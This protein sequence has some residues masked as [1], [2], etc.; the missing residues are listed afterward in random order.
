MPEP[1][2]DLKSAFAGIVA[3]ARAQV[4]ERAGGIARPRR[5]RRPPAQ[6]APVPPRSIRQRPGRGDS[7]TIPQIHRARVIARHAAKPGI[8]CRPRTRAGQTIR[9]ADVRRAE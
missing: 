7:Q 1:E 4:A 2:A 9:H 5:I 6:T 8:V 3:E